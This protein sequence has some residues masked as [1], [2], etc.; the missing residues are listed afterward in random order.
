MIYKRTFP[1]AIAAIAFVALPAA[2]DEATENFLKS[3]VSSIDNAPGWNATYANLASEASGRTILGGFTVTSE[4]PGFS[5]T[6][7]TIGV[8]GYDAGADAAFAAE[9]VALDGG[10]VVANLVT[11]SIDDAVLSGFALPPASAFTWNS[12]RPYLAMVKAFGA[13]AG[14][15]MASGRIGSFVLEQVF[16]GEKS[17]TTYTN[18]ALDNWNNGKIAT[19][20]AGPLTAETPSGDTLVALQVA[21]AES[22]DIDLGAVA[23]VL[24]PDT[25]VGGRGDMVWHT[26]LGRT[27][28]EDLI[29]AVPGVTV[30]IAEAY[31]EDFRVRQPETGIEAFL[32]IGL[33]DFEQKYE[34]PAAAAKLLGALRAFGIG[35]FAI[36][37][38]DVEAP[39]VDKAHMDSFTISDFSFDRIGEFALEGVDAAVADQGAVAIGRIAFGDLVFPPVEAIIA[40]GEAEDSGADVDVSSVL[41]KLGFFEAVAVDVSVEAIVEAALERFRLDLSDYVGPVPTTVALD[42][43]DAD[44]PVEAI[45]EDQAREML[46]AL[47]YERVRIDAGLRLAWSDAGEIDVSEYRVGIRDFGSLSGDARLSGL[48]PSEYEQLDDEAVLEKLSF[49]GGS[50]TILDQ[51]IVGRA[52]GMQAGQLNADPDEFRETFAM[53]LPYMLTFLGDNTLV[54]QVTPIIQSFVRTNGGSITAIAKPAQPVPMTLLAEASESAPLTLLDILAL[55]FTGV[56]GDE[57]APAAG[58]EREAAP[59]EPAAPEAPAAPSEPAETAPAAPSKDPGASKAK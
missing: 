57:P 7:E 14:I 13:F 55:E 27:G 22:R 53:G 25:Y 33:P 52:V 5:L 11:L 35:R 21:R 2:A 18:V 59:S 56:A 17:T 50:I 42:I 6:F 44:M 30:R 38:L 31:T 58:S 20:S 9:E 10:K 29:V 28:Y 32:D 16:E 36:L 46:T 15:S 51:S 26:A 45:E 39:G 48:L 8:A 23:R 49:L 41:P 4:E 54:Q 3:W 43:V 1:A 40:A 24:D 12:E 19:L 34:E 37:G 47:G